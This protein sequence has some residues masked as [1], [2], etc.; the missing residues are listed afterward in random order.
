MLLPK[1]YLKI[2]SIDQCS[3]YL[4]HLL[5]ICKYLDKNQAIRQS[6]VSQLDLIN[7]PLLSGDE[8]N[9]KTL[10]LDECGDKEKREIGAEVDVDASSVT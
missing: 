6:R 5:H 1:A 7:L 10:N 3:K 9:R 8:L 4:W 2:Q